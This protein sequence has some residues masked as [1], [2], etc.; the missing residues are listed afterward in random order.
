MPKRDE[1]SRKSE[2]KKK[3]KKNLLPNSVHIRPGQKIPKK[4]E[5]KK[6]KKLKNIFPAKFLVKTGRDRPKKRKK[7]FSL[8]FRSYSARER[9][10]RKK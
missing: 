3:K 9:K 10:F 7:K 6:V 4:V 1:I 8:E 2:K 5:K